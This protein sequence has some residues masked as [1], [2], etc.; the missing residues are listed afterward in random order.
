M[1]SKPEAYAYPTTKA[2]AVLL[3]AEQGRLL[4]D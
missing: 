2:I 3:A 1:M 4:F